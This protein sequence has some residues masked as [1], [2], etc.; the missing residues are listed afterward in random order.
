MMLICL[1]A[2]GGK[3]V[4][5]N[6]CLLS[7]HWHCYYSADVSVTFCIVLTVVTKTL[8]FVTDASEFINLNNPIGLEISYPIVKSRVWAYVKVLISFY[9]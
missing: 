4:F 8:S 1:S 7:L 5:L 2:N 9:L 3:E 6:Q